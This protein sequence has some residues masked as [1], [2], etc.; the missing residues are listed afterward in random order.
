MSPTSEMFGGF[1]CF[2]GNGVARFFRFVILVDRLVD[3]V[4]GARSLAR[5]R[6]PRPRLLNLV[7]LAFISALFG[8]ASLSCC[9]ACLVVRQLALVLLLRLRL[10]YCRLDNIRKEI[11]CSEHTNV[12]V[13]Y[14][15]AHKEV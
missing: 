11:H 5:A 8:L 7:R 2:V 13:K 12:F 14:Y 15:L 6:P 1:D 10:V 9:R 4:V 3:V